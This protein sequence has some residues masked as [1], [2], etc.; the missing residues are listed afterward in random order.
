MSSLVV[1]LWRY[2]N[3]PTGKKM[4][5]YTMVSVISTGV[6]TVV[7]LV[8]YG[9]L[10]V[11]SEVPS[12]LFGNVVATVPSYYLNRRWAWGKTGR[13]H[14]RREVI[15]FWTLSIAGILLSIAT[16]SEA[17]HIGIAHFDHHHA[18]R[19]VLVL[20]ANL[21]A[22]G[23][24]WIVKFLV[25]NRLFHVPGAH[26]VQTSPDAETIAGEELVEAELS[27]GSS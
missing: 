24:L 8:V 1:R 17:R 10:R 18:I 26:G 11:W 12:A 16:E 4:F 14:V 3:T 2:Y 19:T 22:F 5:R 6:S 27:R 9:V 25:F 21:L 7:L 15:P 20:G 23:I 13:S